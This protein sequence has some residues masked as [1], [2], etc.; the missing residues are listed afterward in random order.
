MKSKP[1]KYHIARAV[2]KRFPDLAA[3]LPRKR[4][5]WEKEHYRM[6]IFDAAAVGV[7]YFMRRRSVNSTCRK[8]KQVRFRLPNEAPRV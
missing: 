6:R 8:T 4:K 2:A 5:I 3:K 1:N 7:A